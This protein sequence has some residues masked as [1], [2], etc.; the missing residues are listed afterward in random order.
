MFLVQV[1]ITYLYYSRSDIVDA[2][3]EM[4]NKILVYVYKEKL[5]ENRN[6][7]SK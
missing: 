1:F 3:L 5:S 4:I 6:R 7:N 2:S